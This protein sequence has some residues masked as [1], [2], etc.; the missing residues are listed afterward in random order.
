M[1]RLLVRPITKEVDKP[2]GGGGKGTEALYSAEI[3]LD[4]QLGC[5]LQTHHFKKPGQFADFCAILSQRARNPDRPEPLPLR[6]TREQ[7]IEALRAY[8]KAGLAFDAE[9]AAERAARGEAKKET[10]A[11]TW[12][13][14]AV[15][16]YIEHSG[17]PAPAE[18]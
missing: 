7:C 1:S 2:Q 16:D 11:A 14:D 6:M 13:I 5:T 3:L 10:A 18:K 15:L 8:R 12:P 4:G 17:F 9:K